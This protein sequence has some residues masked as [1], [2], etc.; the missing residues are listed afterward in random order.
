[1]GMAPH[2]HPPFSI[3]HPRILRRRRHGLLS[4]GPHRF[5]P[6]RHP[7]RPLSP[8]EK[9]PPARRTLVASTS[10]RNIRRHHPP[11][12][13]LCPAPHPQRQGRLVVRIRR[14]N[15]RQRGKHPPLVV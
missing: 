6:P 1:M 7:H 12:A 10:H 8:S 4:Q 11:L 9:M 15:R 3:L 5:H 13:P 14:R 2:L